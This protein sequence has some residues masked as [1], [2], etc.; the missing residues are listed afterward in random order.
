MSSVLAALVL[1][2]S[3][4]WADTRR[5]ALIAGA[6][7]GGADRVGLLYAVTDA[8]AIGGVLAELGG[9]PRSNQTVLI[10]PDATVMREAIAN[11]ANT[12]A[13]AEAVGMRTEVVFYYSGHSD[14]G[15]LLLGETRYGY[16]EL[17]RNL[18]SIPSDVKVVIL[19]SCASG[20]M[21]RTKGGV[22]RPAFLEDRTNDV[23]GTAYVMSSAADEASQESD[24]V[25]ASYFTHF[26][27]SGMRGAADR[28]LDGRV[29]L[30]E[31]WDF[32]ARETLERT[33]RTSIGAQHPFFHRDLGGHGDF[34]FTDL[35]QT[36]SSLVFDEQLAG[37]LF[38]R[39]ANGA[40]VAELA[41]PRNESVE[42]ALS[43][44]T[45]AVVLQQD[46][47][48]FEAE[49]DIGEAEHMLVD[50]LEFIA[51]DAE[52]V[53]ARGGARP[54]PMNAVIAAPP[55]RP[56]PPAPPVQPPPLP[57]QAEHPSPSRRLQVNGITEAN[58]VNFQL[59]FVA[60]KAVKTEGTQ[61]STFYNQTE[62][63]VGVQVTLLANLAASAAG[64]QA[65]SLVNIATE[66]LSGVQVAMINSAS[67]VRGVQVGLVNHTKNAYGVQLGLINAGGDGAG[68]QVGLLNVARDYEG[69][70]VGVL[71]FHR[72]GYNHFFVN[73]GHPENMQIAVSLGSRYI[74][75]SIQAGISF[76]S[77]ASAS[78]A[79]GPGVHLPI[80][81]FYLDGDVAPGWR[82]SAKDADAGRGSGVDG[83]WLLRGRLQAGYTLGKS[84]AFQTGPTGEWTIEDGGLAFGWTAGMRF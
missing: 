51:I 18:E 73:G 13:Q 16:P 76:K 11:L 5:F 66:R 4:A 41:K 67:E 27:V 47:Q 84:F 56:D 14:E 72:S 53:R 43:A 61:L 10:E 40:L 9:I 22:A 50:D 59:G 1:G 55:V 6:N 65:S 63:L 15:G 68:L 57:I 60:N 62:Q 26:L 69:A 34:V 28:S 81:K 49:F 54:E 58:Q 35:T 64:V 37:R 23:E 52:T 21:V 19:D 7:D 31:A 12:V 17:K 30:H 78:L 45:Y 25:G 33:E 20:A 32:A 39:D 44:G 48:R 79:A 75:T 74:Y 36:T 29:T 77:G 82:V 70:A 24:V 3:S 83:A 2:G 8:Q 42:L 80:Q 71:N 38:V 46:D